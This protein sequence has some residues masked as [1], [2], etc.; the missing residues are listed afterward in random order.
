[1]DK[2]YPNYT[3]QAMCYILVGYD[4]GCGKSFV[5]IFNHF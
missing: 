5:L 3:Y 2:I 1:M 4:E